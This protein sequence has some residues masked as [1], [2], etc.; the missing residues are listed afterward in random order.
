MDKSIPKNI[1][2]FQRNILIMEFGILIQPLN[3]LAQETLPPTLSDYRIA[4]ARVIA[5]I[6][7]W[8]KRVEEFTRFSDDL[9]FRNEYNSICRVLDDLMS[10]LERIITHYAGDN[11]GNIHSYLKSEVRA[12]KYGLIIALNRVPVEWEPVLFKANTPFTSYLKIKEA[13]ALIENRLHYFDRYLKRDFFF[14]F[15]GEIDREISVRLITTEGNDDYGVNNIIHISK[16]VRQEFKDYQLIKVDPNILHDRNL[17]IDNGI[18]G[19]GPGTD[20]AG[21]ALTNFGPSDNSEEAHRE[22]DDVISK[23]IIIHKS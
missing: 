12:A 1:K 8:Q 17:R 22:F 6:E 11:F 19:L 16:L 10:N 18:F 15:L 9:I 3:D 21:M 14:L 4:T 7:T 5:G 2:A 23:G 13:M 20:R